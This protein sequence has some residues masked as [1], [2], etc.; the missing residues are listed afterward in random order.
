MG[1]TGLCT[2]LLFRLRSLQWTFYSQVIFCFKLKKIWGPK[3]N[4]PE[5]IGQ[6]FFEGSF[7]DFHHAGGLAWAVAQKDPFMPV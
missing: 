6:T 1:G 5:Q 7:L 4:N 3:T 2:T